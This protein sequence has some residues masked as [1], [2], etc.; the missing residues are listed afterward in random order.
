MNLKNKKLIFLFSLFVFLVLIFA[1]GNN[2]GMMDDRNNVIQ[3][4][5]EVKSASVVAP[6]TIDNDVSNGA[7]DYTWVEAILEP[8]CSGS[9]TELDP[10]VIEDLIIDGGGSGNGIAIRDSN[11]FFRIENCTVYNSGQYDAG[12]SLDN[13]YNGNLIGNNCSNNY[14]G[15]LLF[16]GC[17]NNNITGN[18]AN[19]NLDSGIYLANACFENNITGNIANNNLV[20]GIHL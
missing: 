16:N 19:N 6:F 8:W 1:V 9:G 15:I 4:S 12:I 20:C 17:N 18:T 11:V 3:Q 7:G 10:Y 13:T 5:F 2:L 14:Y